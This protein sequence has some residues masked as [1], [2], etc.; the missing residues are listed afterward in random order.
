MPIYTVH[1]P[2]DVEDDVARADRTA[3]VRDGFNVWA[4]LFGPLFLLRHRAW[5]AAAAWIVLV[6]A[7]AFVAHAIGLPGWARFLLL[8]L[9]AIFV[10]L[11]GNDLRRRALRRRGF[12]L[13]EIVSGDDRRDSELAFFRNSV[14][15]GHAVPRPALSMAGSARTP[16]RV[17]G[18][19]DV[20]GF[21]DGEV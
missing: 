20:I 18:R 8:A 17:P 10:G 14:T 7:M 3:F 6:L 9:L 19:F 16:L 4:F 1:V 11:E 15:R 21:S 12:D 13:A 2:G 5:L